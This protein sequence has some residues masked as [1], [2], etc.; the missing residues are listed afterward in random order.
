MMDRHVKTPERPYPETV[1]YYP[2]QDLHHRIQT[3]RHGSTGDDL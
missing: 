1:S 2:D 3:Q